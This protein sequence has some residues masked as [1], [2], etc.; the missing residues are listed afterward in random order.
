MR[1][2]NSSSLVRFL[3][4]LSGCVLTVMLSA[5]ASGSH[6]SVA[7][8]ADATASAHASTSSV[9]TSAGSTT[10][11]TATTSAATTT[12]TTTTSTSTAP[13]PGTGKPP[14]VIGDE[15]FTEQ[16]VLGQLYALALQ[17][18]GYQVSVSRNIGPADVRLPALTSG[19]IAMYPE[20]LGTFI[21]QIAGDSATYTTR[22]EAY[23]AAQD[24]ALAHGLEL[25]NPTPFSDTDAIATTIG[26][27]QQYKIRAIGDL[28]KVASTLTLGWPP[29]PEQTPSLL[30][31]V[32]ATYDLAPAATKPLA[33]GDQYNELN[34]GA[35]QA[36]DVKTTDGE[37]ASGNYRVLRDPANVFGYGNVI[38]VLN[39]QALAVE[40]PEFVATVDRVS[41]LLNTATMRQLNSYVDIAQKDPT[42]VAREFL[43]THGLIPPGPS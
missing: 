28:R 10:T 41:A 2:R 17:A 4:S 16:F 22:A 21:T 5:C 15:N 8:V 29:Q 1:F 14:V 43:E 12:T 33:I 26:Y 38:P 24:W 13:L 20:Y 42:T 6:S 30:P 37:L 34:Q 11:S 32:Q 31:A 7:P 35:V 3:A 23:A 25:L 19:R 27:A 36:A 18:Q 39:S 40:G 9:G